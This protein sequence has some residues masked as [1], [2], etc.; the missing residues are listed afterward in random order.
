MLADCQDSPPAEERILMSAFTLAAQVSTSHTARDSLSVTS[1]R[2]ALQAAQEVM[3]FNILITGSRE[4][5]D[6]F[7]ELT[8][9]SSRASAEVYLWYNLLSDYPD[10]SIDEYIINSR[11]EV[12]TGWGGWTAQGQNEVEETFIFSCPNH[13]EARRKTIASLKALLL[14]YP[15]DGVFL[16]KF[17]FPSPANGLQMVLSCFCPYCQQKAQSQGLD[18]E[19]VRAELGD[20]I[21]SD[22][23]DGSGALKNPTVWLDDLFID[24]PILSQFIRFRCE[25]I[26]SLVKDVRSLVNQMGR[27]LALDLF[28]PFLAPLVGQD[29][30][31][32]SHLADWAKPM[33]YRKAYGPAGFRLEVESLIKGIQSMYHLPIESALEWMGRYYPNVTLANYN[34]MV[35]QVVPLDWMRQEIQH[36]VQSFYPKPII[37][38]LE[39]VNFPG[40]IETTPAM[41][42]EMVAVGIE[43]NVQGAVISWDLLSTPLENISAIRDC[44]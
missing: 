22:P 3:P 32:L 41:V 17:R 20:L 39:T 27:K 26:Y 2:K 7:R 23:R 36:A 29:Y 24:R 31:S 10:Q 5:P 15:F 16:D 12:C 21:L 44:L 34:R 37:M 19:R 6:I 35:E 30:G 38:G 13:P 11:G 28:T 4:L 14:A 40:V 8:S 42:R 43:N 1:V 9:S 18:L 25:S 33:T